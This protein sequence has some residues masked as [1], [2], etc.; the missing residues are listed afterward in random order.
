MSKEWKVISPAG[1]IIEIG[2][3]NA[4]IDWFSK[5][6]AKQGPWAVTTPRARRSGQSFRRILAAL[7][8]SPQSD[9]VFEEALSLARQNN[10]ELLVAHAYDTLT[11]LSYLPADCYED[12]DRGARADAA[13]RLGALVEKARQ[14]AVH[15]HALVL[16]GLPDD[17][18]AA[19]AK[20]LGV[21]LIVCGTHGRRGMS[22]L[23][24]GSVAARIVTRARC[25]VL[26]VRGGRE[27]PE[28]G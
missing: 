22:R 23:F 28:S 14:L 15:C 13:Q 26:T 11:N 1:S 20:K 6:S 9:G 27:N 19:A 12:W 5:P 24:L 16:T 2:I 17:A 10:A 18:I 25:S 8:F 4:L 7:D 3:M 21:D